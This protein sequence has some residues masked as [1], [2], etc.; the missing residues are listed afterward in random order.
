MDND[1]LRRT[2]SG[3]IVP[4][5]G[6]KTMAHLDGIDDGVG[7]GVKGENTDNP[8][9]H[10]AGQGHII[11]GVL[12][13]APHGTGV[14]GTSIQ[15]NGVGGLSKSGVGVL[16]E[17]DT[18]DGV[19]GFSGTGNGVHG[20]TSDA[21]GNGVLAENKSTTNKAVGSL[22]GTDRVFHQHAGVYGET[23]Q[24]GV[25]GHATSISG[26]GVYGN[27]KGGGFGVRGESEGGT[28][29][30]GQ[31]FGAGGLAGRFV[32][33]VEVTGD[34]RLSNQDCAKDFDIYGDEDAEPGTVMVIEKTGGL[35]VSGEAYDKRVAGVISGAGNFR[36][37]I[38]LGKQSS[39]KQRMPIALLGQ[40]YCKVDASSSPIEVGDLLTYAYP[41]VSASAICC[42]RLGLG[43]DVRS[44]APRMSLYGVGLCS[45][46]RPSRV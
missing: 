39:H 19:F 1:F 11:I 25:F 22:A 20:T 24:Q 13:D 4:Q 8:Q 34:I 12:G 32:G 7:Y 37:G 2:D 46:P 36:P 17:S 29:V 45:V 18:G 5:P 35:R 33:D 42:G 41:V 40:V 14:S 43:R 30:Q 21:S 6:E 28:A 27:S 38:V 10:P 23:D 31:S 44:S 9:F 16:G 26:T 3:E 15:G